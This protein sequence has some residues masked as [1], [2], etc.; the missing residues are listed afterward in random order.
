M[1][2]A[3]L[4]ALGAPKLPAG[5]FY[6]VRPFDSGLS[7]LVRVEIRREGRWF[8]FG[9]AEVLVCPSEHESAEA[10]IRL[11]AEHAY[12]KEKVRMESCERYTEIERWFGDHR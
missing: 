8:S 4:I 12:A 1:T 10:A 2:M 5:H 6:R 3:D 7:D 11:G 9:L